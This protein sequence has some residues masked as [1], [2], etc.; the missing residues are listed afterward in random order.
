M[1]RR[2][3]RAGILM[4]TAAV[5]LTS[6]GVTWGAGQSAPE[7]TPV[8]IA[9]EQGQGQEGKFIV[10]AH[11]GKIAL[12]TDDFTIT[13]AIETD[14]DVNGLRAYD[15]ALLERGIEV[16]TYEDVLRLLEDFGS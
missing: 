2:K 11:N 8:E 9:A 1:A 3:I 5:A 15:R 14:I 12:F 16:D 13:P 4:T 6:I 10:R 7:P